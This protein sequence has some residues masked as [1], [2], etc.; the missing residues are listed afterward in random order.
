[1]VEFVLQNKRKDII[2]IVPIENGLYH[3]LF[4]GLAFYLIRYG[5]G[6]NAFTK[7]LIYGGIWGVTTAIIFLFIYFAF[8]NYLIALS[9]GEGVK[10]AFGLFIGYNSSLFL[11]YFSFLL[12]S[13]KRLHRSLPRSF[14]HHLLASTTPTPILHTYKP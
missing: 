5:A 1:L 6:V 12:L 10:L 4:E 8:E 14:S 13:V 9:P 7:S 2:W 3:C 11:F